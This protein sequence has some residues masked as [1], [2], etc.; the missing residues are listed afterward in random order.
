MADSPGSHLRGYGAGLQVTQF[1]AMEARDQ[2]D[3]LAL[4]HDPD[5]GLGLEELPLA[6]H[7][8][9]DWAYLLVLH[10]LLDGRNLIVYNIIGLFLLGLALGDHV[11]PTEGTDYCELLLVF[12]LSQLDGLEHF[13]LVLGVK[14]VP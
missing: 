6:E 12:L 7:I 5:A 9:E 11:G 1:V 4:L 2:P 3:F 8:D 14:S 13:D 10:G